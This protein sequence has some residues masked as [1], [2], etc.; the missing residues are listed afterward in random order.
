MSDMFERF[1]DRARKIMALANQEA[2]RLGHE[3][4]GTEHIL[5]GMIKE[6]SGIGAEVLKKL[7]IGLAQLRAETEK[8]VK[9]LPEKRT[10]KLPQTPQA[11]KVIAYAIEEARRLNH[12]YIG[13]EHILLGLIRDP[14]TVAGQVL[15]KSGL[16]LD[17]VR[18]KVVRIL[19]EEPPMSD[20]GQR[21]WSSPTPSGFTQTMM[22]A[23]RTACSR[24]MRRGRGNNGDAANPVRHTV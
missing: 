24:L 7:D 2:I 21:P 5:L 1:T 4:I 6:G 8:M 15:H 10:G 3:Y 22:R 9:K 20:G 13:T 19:S 14:D 16:N 12:E 11:K 18:D 23:F 17:R